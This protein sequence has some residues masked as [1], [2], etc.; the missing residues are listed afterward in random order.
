MRKRRKQKKSTYTYI[1][2]KQGNLY[3]ADNNTNGI[4]AITPTII[5]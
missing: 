3:H 4:S 1:E 2:D 5:R